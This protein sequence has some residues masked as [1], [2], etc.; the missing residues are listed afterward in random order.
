MAQTFPRRSVE[1][2]RKPTLSATLNGSGA[3]EGT[4]RSGD[5]VALQLPDLD[6]ELRL[7]LQHLLF[8]FVELHWLSIIIL[9]NYFSRVHF[10]KKNTKSKVASIGRAKDRTD[11]NL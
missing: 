2:T 10:Q 8:C 11:E 1:D 6:F 5:F 3:P 7:S 9:F 4:P